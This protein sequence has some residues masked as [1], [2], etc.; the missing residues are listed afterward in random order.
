MEPVSITERE[1]FAVLGVQTRIDPWQADYHGIW[2]EQYMPHDEAVSGLANEEGYYALYW[3]SDEAGKVEFLA[4]RAVG[5][6]DRV[7][8]GLVL[9]EMPASLY[10]VF[11][12]PLASLHSTWQHIG[13]V[14]LPGSA[15]YAADES[16]ACFEYFPPGADEGKAPVSVHVAIKP[17]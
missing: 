4:G 11:E 2:E 8:E 13:D 15:Q 16:R 12:C 7:P 6:V 17:K 14:W 9:R 1:A 3:A 5:D 10:A